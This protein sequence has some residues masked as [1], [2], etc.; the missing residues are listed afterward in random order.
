MCVG[1]YVGRLAA[2][3]TVS[4]AVSN[5]PE[6]TIPTRCDTMPIALSPRRLFKT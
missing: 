1:A 2:L 3:A 4:R 6:P 5:V